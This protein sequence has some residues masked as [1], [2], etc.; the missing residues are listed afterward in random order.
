MEGPNV[1]RLHDQEAELAVSQIAV[2]GGAVGL[3]GRLS[4]P[5]MGAFMDGV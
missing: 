2:R 3:D 4:D 1:A 5:D